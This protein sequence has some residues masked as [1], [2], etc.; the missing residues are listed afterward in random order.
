ME[1][2][3][4]RVWRR[5]VTLKNGIFKSL[6]EKVY[7]KIFGFFYFRITN[8]ADFS[9]YT[10]VKLLDYDV[11]ICITGTALG[12]WSIVNGQ[13]HGWIL[14]NVRTGI[15]SRDM[16]TLVIVTRRLGRSLPPGYQN[17]TKMLNFKNNLNFFSAHK[18]EVK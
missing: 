8:S 7:F 11:I 14:G 9:K 15:V 2:S 3:K 1:K 18:Y 16:K 17:N 13:C 12:Q 10:F 4:E 6:R 5:T